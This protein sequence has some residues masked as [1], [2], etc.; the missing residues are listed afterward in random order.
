M[1]LQISDWKRACIAAAA[2]TGFAAA[3][4]FGIHPGGFE[5]QV[6]WFFALLPATLAVY[7]FSDY[8]YKV[9]PHAEPV[10][11]WILVIAF[12]F[13]WYWA[14]SYAVIKIRRFLSGA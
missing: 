1:S 4:M 10:V 9:A 13:G 3:I 2:L 6:A 5:G 7:P 12:N 11:F 14:I 8:I